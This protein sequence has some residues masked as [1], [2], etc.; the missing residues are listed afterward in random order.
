MSAALD[1]SQS[2]EQQADEALR[3]AH[4]KSECNRTT[5]EVFGVLRWWHSSVPGALSRIDGT[6]AN[7]RALR[8]TEEDAW[9][10]AQRLF[11]RDGATF[12]EV[13]SI[14]R[15]CDLKR[16]LVLP[17]RHGDRNAPRSKVLRHWD[18]LAAALVS[19]AAL[20][21]SRRHAPGS[22]IRTTH[23]RVHEALVGAGEG[24]GSP[25]CKW[26]KG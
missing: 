12:D 13:R 10:I 18:E 14:E 1:V 23:R 5:G 15:Q 8:L 17:K 24:L 6:S 9:G 26:C 19:R 16:K 2:L 22:S 11:S 4:F 3:Q 20:S 25:G 7:V 21:R